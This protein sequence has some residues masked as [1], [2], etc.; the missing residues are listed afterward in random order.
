MHVFCHHIYEYRKG[1]RKLILFTTRQANEA[2]VRDKLS[3]NEI[4][5]VIHDIG[6][7]KINVFL[8][9]PAC[10]EV[11]RCVGKSHLGRYTDEEDFILGAMLGYDIR[12]QC[13][14]YLR[15]KRRA[16]APAT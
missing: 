13:R 9:D 2:N 10:I 4:S 11:V 7:G 5:H 3:R 8:G 16:R 1:L 12:G 15:R 14:R 6:G